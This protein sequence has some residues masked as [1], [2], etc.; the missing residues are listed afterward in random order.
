MEREFIFFFE[1]S[2]Y[3]A[4]FRIPSRTIVEPG[5]DEVLVVPA[6]ITFYA[7]PSWT[8]SVVSSSPAATQATFT[9]EVTKVVTVTIPSWPVPTN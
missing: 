4:A 2:P 5:Y 1:I 8:R 3:V 9:T 6:S 7:E